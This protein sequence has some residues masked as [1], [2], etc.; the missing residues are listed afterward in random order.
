[1]DRDAPIIGRDDAIRSIRDAYHD[2]NMAFVNEVAIVLQKVGLDAK[3]VLDAAGLPFRTGLVS[4]R[5]EENQLVHA[6]ELTGY[7]PQVLTAG[8]RLN[9][10]MGRYIAGKTV[11]QLIDARRLVE[12]S[13][14]SILGLSQVENCGDIR[15]SQVVD[16]I[17][18]LIEFGVTCHVHD[19]LVDNRVAMH[20]YGITLE[21]WEELQPADALILAVPHDQILAKSTPE[22]MS[23]ISKQGCFIDVRCVVDPSPFR[24]AGIRVWR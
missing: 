4:H 23:L 9:K 2:L 20:E 6:A 10:G 13:R 14:V 15:D 18:E 8:Q 16:V 5:K 17:Q 24:Q 11:Q 1:M 7:H 12:G 3:E 22:M 21:S 19:P